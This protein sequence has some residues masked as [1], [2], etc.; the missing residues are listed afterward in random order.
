MRYFL[1][2]IV[3]LV[4]ALTGR[5]QTTPDI[6]GTW[7]AELRGG[8]VFLQVRTAPPPEWN[9]NQWGSDWSSGQ[10]VAADEFAGLPVNDERL[11]LEQIKFELHREAGTLAFGDPFATAVAQGSSPS[12]RVRSSPPS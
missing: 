1:V 11:T 4:Q 5:A 8:N 6:N 7:T 9:G 2:A 3:A 10:T 12:R